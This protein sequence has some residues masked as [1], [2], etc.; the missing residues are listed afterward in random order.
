MEVAAVI[1]AWAISWFCPA[2]PVSH[3]TI[4]NTICGRGD[5]TSI[6]QPKLS[7]NARIILLDDTAFT[8][9]ISRWSKFGAPGVSAVVQVVTENDVAE[10]I[11][12][13]NTHGIP[14]FAKS[15]GHGSI[16]SLGQIRDGIE[17]WMDQLDSV[18]V[19]PDGNTAT[20]GGGVLS[21]KV[22]HTLWEVGKQTVVGGCE[23]TSLVGPG[24][25]GGHGFLQ[26]KYGLIS[27]QFVSMRLA[28]ADGHIETVSATSHPDLWWAMQGAGHNFGI[29]TEVTSKIY[30]I[31]DDGVWSYES[32]IFTHDK[33][34]AIFDRINTLFTNS[35]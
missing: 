34:E 4:M 32:Y 8:D 20:F 35:T 7:Q 29:V 15:G 23:C 18:T 26:G 10:T 25:G 19:S 12:Y 33:V 16:T 1:G 3:S 11:K 22:S 6:L 9:S 27:D 21:K 13:A 31:E 5:I 24:L 30:D 2:L 28:I 17:I 14:F